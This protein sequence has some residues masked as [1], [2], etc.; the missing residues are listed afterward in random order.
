L[1]TTALMRLTMM[2]GAIAGGAGEDDAAALAD[3]GESLGMAYQI[4]DDLLDELGASDELGKPV[5]QDSRHHRSN[6]VSELGVEGARRLA[7]SLTEEGI[8]SLRKRFG[9]RPEVDLLSDA[10]VMILQDAG[11]QAL[12]ATCQ[13]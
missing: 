1:K 6:Y 10:A 2:A 12:I 4:C 8:A 11:T 5:K 7:A 9:A 13:T 3:F